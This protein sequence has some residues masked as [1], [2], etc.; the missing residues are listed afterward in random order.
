MTNEDYLNLIT[1]EHRGKEKFEATVVAG[2]SPFSK[3]QAV[4]LDLPADF[5]I[6]SAVGVQLDAVGAWIGRSRRIDTPLVGVYFAWDDLASDGWESGIWKGPFD[7][8]SGLVDLPDDS[9]RVLL[10]A[11]IAANS[12][13][14]TIPGAYAIWAT[15]FTN[16]QLVIQDNQDMSM[17]V[18]I[19]GQPLSIV[20]QALLTNG[21]IPLKPE[22][23]RI[24]YYAIAPAAGA[25]F[26]WDTDE[27]TALAGWDT[28]QWATELIPA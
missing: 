10:K 13:D 2:V 16:S 17:V 26:A 23:V 5:D 7:P 18:G 14:G 11:K 19:A 21:Y 9:Y 8:D 12:W 24:Q 28:G 27:S 20:D 22:G 15:V 3:L 4:M 6:D 1:S 25:L